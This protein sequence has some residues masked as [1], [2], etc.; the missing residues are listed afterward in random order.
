M[1]AVGAASGRNLSPILRPDLFDTPSPIRISRELL[2]R[3]EFIPARSL[4][5]LAA[6]W[7]QFQVHDWVNH[8]RH[9]LGGKED[10]VVKLPSGMTCQNIV[11][12]PEESSRRDRPSHARDRDLR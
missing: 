8:A 3:K 11:G 5:I 12:G 6:A 4:N 7:I 2:Q 9:P 1:G 10:V